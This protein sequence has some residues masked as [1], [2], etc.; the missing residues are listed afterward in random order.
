M[1]KFLNMLLL[2]DFL[3]SDASFLI[4]YARKILIIFPLFVVPSRISSLTLLKKFK[5]LDEWIVRR[6]KIAAKYD[7]ELRNTPL[8]IPAEHIDNKHAYYVYVVA[9]PNKDEI[10]SNLAKKNIFLCPPNVSITSLYQV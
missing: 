9:H 3:G 5:F 6:R 8:K 10:M 4:F 1:D 2:S 7:K